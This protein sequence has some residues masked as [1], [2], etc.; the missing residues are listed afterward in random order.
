MTQA[1]DIAEIFSSFC[2]DGERASEF[3]SSVIESL[4]SNG[5]EIIFDFSGVR[6]M[7]SSFCNALIANLIARHG[8]QLLSRIHFINCNETVKIHLRSALTLVQLQS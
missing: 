8:D 3:S 1:F 5:E 4:A 7:N 6:N 2:A